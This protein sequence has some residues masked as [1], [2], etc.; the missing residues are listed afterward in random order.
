MYHLKI[1]CKQTFTIWRSTTQ[2]LWLVIK[3]LLRSFQTS[4]AHADI[5]YIHH[6]LPTCKL[7][8]APPTTYVTLD[9]IALDQLGRNTSAFLELLNDEVCTASH[10]LVRIYYQSTRVYISDWLLQD[11][12]DNVDFVPT[13]AQTVAGIGQ[14]TFTYNS[15]NLTGE[16]DMILRASFLTAEKVSQLSIVHSNVCWC[17]LITIRLVLSI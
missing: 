8:A 5:L 16:T 14:I 4:T 7:Q 2:P 10:L 6:T 9:V 12:S 11:V 3:L 13:I 15:P 17:S 1:M